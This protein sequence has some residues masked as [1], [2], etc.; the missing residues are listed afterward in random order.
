MET[1]FLS[2]HDF[3]IGRGYMYLYG[4]KLSS[5]LSKNNQ[6]GGGSHA[7]KPTILYKPCTPVRDI[8]HGGESCNEEIH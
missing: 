6:F 7:R 4:S 5:S 3:K 8:G 1:A 2:S